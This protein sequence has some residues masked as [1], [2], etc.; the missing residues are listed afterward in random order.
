MLMDSGLITE[1]F[2]KSE[3]PA[4]LVSSKCDISSELSQTDLRMNESFCNPIEGVES[5]QTSAKSP[6]T[7]KR[8]V[9]IMLKKVMIQR[10]GKL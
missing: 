5:L 4:V 10:T 2:S 9:S 8:C 1:A 3:I 6:E 7:Y